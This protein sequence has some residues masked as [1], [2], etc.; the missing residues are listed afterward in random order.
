MTG[1]TTSAIFALLLLT[2]CAPAPM[3]EAVLAEPAPVIAAEPAGD[4]APSARKLDP[5]AECASGND[6]IG[7]TGCPQI[8]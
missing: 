4:A 8:D 7:G 3:E 6:G 5:S 2:A 1:R